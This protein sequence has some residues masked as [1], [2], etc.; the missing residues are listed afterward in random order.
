MPTV[1]RP[2]RRGLLS[3]IVSSLSIAPYLPGCAARRPPAVPAAPDQVMKIVARQWEFV[4]SR[5]VLKKGV[6]VVLELVSADRHHGFSAPGLGAHGEIRP[7]EPTW[8]RLVPKE[9][10]T[11]PFHCDVFCGEGHEEMTG[12]IVVAP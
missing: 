2:A 8:L 5:I 12:Q 7:G 9:V 1:I 4:P 3:L 10:G 11:F 6:P